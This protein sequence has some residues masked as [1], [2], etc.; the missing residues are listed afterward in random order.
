M[1]FLDDSDI[2]STQVPVKY[3]SEMAEAIK[4]P[5]ETLK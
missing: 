4:I 5:N 3:I 1:P 2:A